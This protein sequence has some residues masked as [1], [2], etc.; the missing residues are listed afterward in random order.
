MA[1]ARKMTP[2]R[3]KIAG[4]VLVLALLALVPLQ[5]NSF[6]VLSSVRKTIGLQIQ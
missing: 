1:N 5:V 2:F 6:P 4:K 3:E